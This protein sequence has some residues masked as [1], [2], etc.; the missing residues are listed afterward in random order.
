MGTKGPKLGTEMNRRSFLQGMAGILS[1]GVAPAVMADGIAS[2]I[3]MPVRQLWTPVFVEVFDSTGWGLCWGYM[4]CDMPVQ[5]A[6]KI[7][8]AVLHD[9]VRGKVPLYLNGPDVVRPGDL[10]HL[11]NHTIHEPFEV[12]V[13]PALRA[14]LT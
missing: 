10:L 11:S 8:L 12:S 9:P 1:A 3:L 13:S 4:G 7:Y 5:R 6:G 2:R 14:K